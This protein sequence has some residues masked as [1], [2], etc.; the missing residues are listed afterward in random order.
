MWKYSP[1]HTVSNQI[2]GGAGE[3]ATAILVVV[4]NYESVLAQALELT[5]E[6]RELLAIQVQLSLGREPGAGGDPFWDRELK[7]QLEALVS[8][9][10]D[11]VG[12]GKFDGDLMDSE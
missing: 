10:D 12:W 7:R 2:T 3:P 5:E 8:G 6:E 4:S 1:C 11:L 9:G